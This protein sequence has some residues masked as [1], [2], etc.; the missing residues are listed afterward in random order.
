MATLTGH[1]APLPYGNKE[2]KRFR[3][4]RTLLVSFESDSGVLGIMVHL[5]QF[6]RSENRG[7][8]FQHAKP[9]EIDLRVGDHLTFHGKTMRIVEIEAQ[10]QAYYDQ[11]PAILTGYLIDQGPD[12]RRKNGLQSKIASRP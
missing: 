9:R 1:T 11:P 8:V 3:V 5:D 4:I 6:G 7:T 12:W 10:S 2:P